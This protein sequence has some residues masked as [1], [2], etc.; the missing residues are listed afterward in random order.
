MKL[1]KLTC[2][3]CNAQLNIKLENGKEEIF[4][5]Y[6]GQKFLIDDETKKVQIDINKKIVNEAKIIRETNKE[7]ENKRDFIILATILLISI[8]I[9]VIIF[10]SE[11]VNKI[12]AEKEGKISAGS[13][14]ELIGKDYKSVEAHLEAAGFT[15]IELID[16]HDSGI[17]FWNNGKVETI[18]IGGSTSFGTTSYFDKDTKIIISYH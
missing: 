3:N 9:L 2:P 5:P 4:C 18:S 8:L 6:C 10:G 16:L 7:K 12:V 1:N 11:Q 15:N 14:S 17:M 13:Y